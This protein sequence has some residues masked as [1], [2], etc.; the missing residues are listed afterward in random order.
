MSRFES[1]L[2]LGA[3]PIHACRLVILAWLLTVMFTLAACYPPAAAP[4]DATAPA[5]TATV[6][7]AEPAPA[8]PLSD[9][10][11][12]L[13]YSGIL[14]NAVQL[15]NGA[16]EYQDGSSSAPAVRLMPE[17]IATG[18]LNGDGAEDAV[19]TLRNETSGTGRFVYLVA[20]LDALSD[21]TPTGALMLGDRIKVKSLAIG[22]GQVVADLVV[23]G[24]NDGLCC[25]TLD[26]TRIFDFI[27][28]KLIERADK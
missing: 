18:D 25:P 5:P 10:L 6:A 4:A 11:G 21:P 28:N 23:Q 22:E 26:A 2:A 9:V 12:N 17:T 27:D 14:D 16:G 7:P 3:P 24:P 20:V 13:A 8:R 1:R 19:V 15:T